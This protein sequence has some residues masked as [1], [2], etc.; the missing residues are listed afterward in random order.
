M[1]MLLALGG[2]LVSV[3]ATS[4]LPKKIYTK[5]EVVLQLG[6]LDYVFALANRIP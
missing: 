1:R 5:L 6:I 2:G 4:V 3:N